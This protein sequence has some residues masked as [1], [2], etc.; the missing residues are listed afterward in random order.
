MDLD[1][2]WQPSHG[3]G[4]CDMHVTVDRGFDD[5]VEARRKTP[6]QAGISGGATQRD[7]ALG[8]RDLCH[9]PLMQTHAT[10][11]ESGFSL[12]GRSVQ[13]GLAASLST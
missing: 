10:M 6:F 11:E 7:V 2:R 9:S 13:I 5:Q 8:R 1:P 12:F 4:F 3:N